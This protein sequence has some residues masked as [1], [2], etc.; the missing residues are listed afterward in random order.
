M[1]L[2]GAHWRF[3]HG[4]AGVLVFAAGFNMR[5]FTDNAFALN[6]GFTTVTVGDQPVAAEKLNGNTPQIADGDGVGKNIAIFIRC[7][8]RLDIDALYMYTNT[9]RIDN[10]NPSCCCGRADNQLASWQYCATVMF[11]ARRVGSLFISS[12]ASSVY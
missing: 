12:S 7:G 5:L 3:Q 9:G 2:H 1:A 4:T 6:F 11:S 8:L 10:I